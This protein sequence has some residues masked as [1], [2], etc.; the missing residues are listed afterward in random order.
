[1]FSRVLNSHTIFKRLAKALISL[2]VCACWSEHLLVAHT[3][4]LEI[5]CRGSIIAENETCAN[6]FSLF[7]ECHDL[8]GVEVGAL[9]TRRKAPS[10]IVK[11]VRIGECMCVTSNNVIKCM[12]QYK[13]NSPIAQPKFLNK[14]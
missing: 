5:S 3:I 9:D 8:K 1:M 6:N 11:R 14:I 12:M 10:I 2:R 4:L 13:T 7:H